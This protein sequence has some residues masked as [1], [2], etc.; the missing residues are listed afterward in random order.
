MGDEIGT[1]VYTGSVKSE[2][3]DCNKHMNVAYYGVAFDH[4]VDLLFESFGVTDHYIENSLGSSFAV[5]SHM[6]YQKEMNEGDEFRVTAQ[7]LAYDDKRIHQFQRLYHASEGYLA[8]TAEW[9]NLHVD[10]AARRVTPWPESIQESLAEFVSGQSAL[11]IS[12]E[13]GKRMLISDPLYS[14][15]GSQR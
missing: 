14:S 10:L 8:A 5:E 1:Y 15:Y 12:P 13:I 11:E 3:I 9:M 6:T 4:A 2:W 7:I